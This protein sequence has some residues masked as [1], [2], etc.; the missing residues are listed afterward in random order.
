MVAPLSPTVSTIGLA[1]PLR[2]KN[3]CGLVGS[4][5]VCIQWFIIGSAL[6][7]INGLVG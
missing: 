6:K 3:V 5:P 4:D 2:L 7:N 1:S